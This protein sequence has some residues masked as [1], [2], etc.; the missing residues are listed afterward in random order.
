MTSWRNIMLDGNEILDQF[1]YR[2]TLLGKLLVLDDQHNLGT[3]K[4]GLPSNVCLNLYHMDDTQ[5]TLNRAKG[6]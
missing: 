4:Q 3:F 6:L 2:V 5:T 1:S